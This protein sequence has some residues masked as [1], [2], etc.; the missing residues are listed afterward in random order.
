[1]VSKQKI[2]KGLDDHLTNIYCTQVDLEM[3]DTL[4]KECKEL[5]IVELRVRYSNLLNIR[6]RLQELLVQ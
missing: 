5:S 6:T 4:P 2:L 3:D 1:M